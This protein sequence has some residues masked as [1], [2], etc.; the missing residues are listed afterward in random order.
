MRKPISQE[1]LD[2]WKAKQDKVL[3][4]TLD[5]NEEFRSWPTRPDIMV[6]RNGKFYYKY[7]QSTRQCG[8]KEGTACFDK[9]GYP[10]MMEVCII[11][12]L[13]DGTKK[14]KVYNVGRLVL[15]AFG[16]EQTTDENGQLRTEVDH[17]SQDPFDNRLEN[18]RW[19]TRSENS[20]NRNM[21]QLRASR[22]KFAQSN[23]YNSWVEYLADTRK[24]K[25]EESG[26]DKWH[27]YVASKHP[28]GTFVKDPSKPRKKPDIEQLR[29]SREK[30]A[31]AKG[32][33]SWKEYLAA[34]KKK[35]PEKAGYNSW[36]EYIAAAR[37]KK[38]EE[39]GCETWGEY[40][41]SKHE[42]NKYRK[43]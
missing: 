24:K 28:E 3:E 5:K 23:G 37:K 40:V 8:V 14:P 32:Y 11:Q 16:V 41:A 42:G 10:L 2:K 20:M 36:G 29:N 31:K 22:N 39:A 6:S 7:P 17:I 9:S 30:T 34:I 43:D 21:D 1:I 12:T 26:F 33:N 27:E 19:A 4:E 13:P 15:E 38:M 25:M 18:L 35:K